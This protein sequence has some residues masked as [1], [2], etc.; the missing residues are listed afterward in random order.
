M[1]KFLK[2][3]NKFINYS[4]K[5]AILPADGI[6][7][8]V[9]PCAERILKKYTDFTFVHLETGFETFQK[10]GNSLPEKTIESLKHCDGAI[11]G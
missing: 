7:K 6:G 2:N 5:I 9:V 11:F 4:K 10:Y 1:R 3:S 8:E